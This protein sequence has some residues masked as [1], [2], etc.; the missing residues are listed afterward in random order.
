MEDRFQDPKHIKWA[1]DVKERDDYTCQICGVTDA[2]LNSHHKDSW[3]WCVDGRYNVDNVQLTTKTPA[4]PS[5]NSNGSPCLPAAI[6]P[7]Q[8]KPFGV[9]FPSLAV[10]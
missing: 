8:D 4:K 10:G 6:R 1:K 3:D 2:Y 7:S 5:G 9:S